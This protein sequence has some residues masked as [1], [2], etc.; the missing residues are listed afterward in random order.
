MPRVLLTMAQQ[1]KLCDHYAKNRRMSCMALVAWS[2]GAFDLIAMPDKSTVNNILRGEAKL[3]GITVDY[4]D[5]QRVRPA[6]IM[7]L[8]RQLVQ[9]LALYEG[10][11]SL[12]Y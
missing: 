3:R 7:R 4:Q 12:T 8:E 5:L 10:R 9:W 11:S 1:L 2:Q 6:Q